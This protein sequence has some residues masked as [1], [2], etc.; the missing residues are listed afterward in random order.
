M[1]EDNNKV[2]IEHDDVTC[3]DIVEKLSD[4][5]VDGTSIYILGDF[6]DSISRN[7]TP[8]L[9]KLIQTQK[10]LKNGK[11]E[12]YINSS[13]GFCYELY[14]LLSLISLA[15]SYGIKICTFNMGKAFSC[16]SILAT[17]GDERKMFKYATQLIHLGT[18]SASNK[19]FKQ[20][21]RTTKRQKEHFL[22]VV[23]LYKEHSN[24][25]EAKIK[26]LLLDDCCYLN[27]KECLKYG[28]V[29]EICNC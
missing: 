22:N 20:L 27:A 28:L 16:G 11:I 4:N 25:S 15:K 13:G 6:D 12:F 1:N 26:E 29:D 18:I 5:Y 9:V 24:L 14:E 2:S 3:I 10:A 17:V 19:T 8:N 23:N 21:E 7:I